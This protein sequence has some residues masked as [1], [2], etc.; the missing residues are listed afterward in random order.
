MKLLWR[1]F[2]LL[3]AAGGVGLLS[4]MAIEPSSPVTRPI[5]IQVRAENLPLFDPDRPKLTRFGA[6][7]YRSAVALS[8]SEP[9]FGGFSGIWRSPDGDRIVAVTDRGFWLTADAV[10]GSRGLAGLDNAVLAPIL[11]REGAPPDAERPYDVE[12]LVIE[13]GIAHIGVERIQAAMRFDFARDGVLARGE[14]IATPQEARL[15]Q[16]NKGPE[17]I[18]IAPPASPV[19]GSLVIIAERARRGDDAPT[20]GFI[21]TGGSK[22]TFDVARSDGFDVTDMEFLENGDI[23][24]LERRFR[25]LTGVAARIRRISGETLQPGALLD[26]PVIFEAGPQHQ[27]DNMEGLATHRAHD[28]SLILTLISDDNFSFLQRTLMLE[29]VLEDE[30]VSD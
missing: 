11:D 10:S 12:A 15:W 14:I 7:R 2:V 17:A 30:I 21:L 13:D 6:L 20:Q 23:L 27:I 5:A 16:S 18:G 1:G 24:L 3:G 28:G 25:I 19:P 26:G 29:F 4:Y 22:G 8:A 9:N